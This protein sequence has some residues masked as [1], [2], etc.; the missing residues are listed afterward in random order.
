MNTTRPI[1]R[2]TP[3]R[4][5]RL[6]ALFGLCA[7]ALV[8]TLALTAST[9]GTSGAATLR[10]V[11]KQSAKHKPS[12]AKSLSAFQACLSKH[13]LKLP[14]RGGSSGGPP[15]SFSGGTPPSF[16]GSGGFGGNSKAQAALKQCASLQPKGGFPGGP[17]GAGGSSSTAFASYRNCMKLHGVT[18]PSVTPGSNTSTPSTVDTS[19]PTYQAA[20]AACKALLP[21]GTGTT[22]GGSG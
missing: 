1:L 14:A 10:T 19:S 4:G 3:A 7:L 12:S 21:T 9:S 20:Q 11:A 13:G 8:F 2:G 6:G 16:G 17:G 18:V 5:L 22:S 15:S